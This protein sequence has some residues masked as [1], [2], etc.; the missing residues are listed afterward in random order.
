MHGLCVAYPGSKSTAWAKNVQWWTRFPLTEL[1]NIHSSSELFFAWL[2]HFPLRLSTQGYSLRK[3][4]H[5]HTHTLRDSR[6]DAQVLENKLYKPHTSWKLRNITAPAECLETDCGPAALEAI[7]P[8]LGGVAPVTRAL[9]P[10]DQACVLGRTS[11]YDYSFPA[12][13]TTPLH[14]GSHSALSSKNHLN[15]RQPCVLCQRHF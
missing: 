5:T 4:K 7:N 13:Y 12:R 10:I 6:W 8:A 1:N 14:C 11:S 3:P 2:L 15:I 9:L